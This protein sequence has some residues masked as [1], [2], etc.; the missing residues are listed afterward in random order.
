MKLTDK[1][2]RVLDYLDRSGKAVSQSGITKA[3]DGW[4]GP[5]VRVLMAHGLVETHHVSAGAF[6]SFYRY[7]ITDAGREAIH[8]LRFYP[9]RRPQ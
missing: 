5:S 9:E 3:F 2:K 6:S 1:Q 4:P 7:G 8:T